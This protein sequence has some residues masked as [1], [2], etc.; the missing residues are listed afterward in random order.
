[1]EKPHRDVRASCAGCFPHAQFQ[2]NLRHL[3]RRAFH[4]CLSRVVLSADRRMGNRKTVDRK[5]GDRKMGDRK[6]GDRKTG[7]RKTGDRK[8][9]VKD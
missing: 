3:A 7:D 6:T 9:G 4:A 8:M 2:C 1:M 5:M